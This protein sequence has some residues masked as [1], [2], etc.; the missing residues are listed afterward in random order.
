MG[1]IKCVVF[2]FSQ[3]NLKKKIFWSHK[4]VVIYH[5]LL[6]EPFLQTFKRNEEMAHGGI[7][8]LFSPFI[9]LSLFGSKV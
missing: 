2:L 9:D 1:F 7:R 6:H 8:A 4:Y 3:L 5:S